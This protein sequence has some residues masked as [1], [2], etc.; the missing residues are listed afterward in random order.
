MDRCTAE[1]A[2]DGDTTIG[3]LS[4]TNDD[5][6]AWW[7]AQFTSPTAIDS[8]Y[9]YLSDYYHAIG[10]QLKVETKM[11]MEDEWKVC[12][13][14]SIETNTNPITSHDI[15]CSEETTANFIR[16]SVSG[17]DLRL[18]EV[19]VTASSKLFHYAM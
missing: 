18:L 10:S 2:L 9:V 14:Y 4:T 1:K 12:Q 16:L 8:I 3:T 7:S 11:K 19:R 15:K 6:I 17:G 13:A 5:G